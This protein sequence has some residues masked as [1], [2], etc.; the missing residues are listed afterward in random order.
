M[1]Y[2]H[3]IHLMLGASFEEAI[4]KV[5]G[6][7]QSYE[8]KDLADFFTGMSGTVDEEGNMVFRTTQ[9]FAVDNG[10][11]LQ[12]NS[13]PDNPFDVRLNQED[14]VVISK[15]NRQ[16]Y[17]RNFFSRLFDKRVT[18]NRRNKDNTLNICIYLPM[19]DSQYW[20]MARECVEAISS[21]TRNIKVDLFMFAP[22]LAYLLTPE[23]E[24]E[25]LPKHM[26]ELT[27]NGQLILKEAV[28]FK[29]ESPLARSL[30]HIIVMQNCN[31][32]GVALDLDWESFVRIV[33]EFVIATMNSYNSLFHPNAE[34]DDRPIHTFGLCV[35]DL[36]KYYYVKYLLSRAYVTI[37]EREGIDQT[38]VDVNIPAQIVQQAF[39]ADDNCYRFYDKFY[40]RRVRGYLTGGRKVE[41]VNAEALKD[42]DSD[43]S[44]FIVHMT[45]FM[46]DPT[47][48]LPQKR[49]ALAQLLG[50]D[51]EYMSGDVFSQNQLIFRDTYADCV[52]MFVAANNALLNKAPQDV[53]V[54]IPEAETA[55]EE[56]SDYPEMLKYYAVLGEEY[57]D[58]KELQKQLK[59]AELRIRRQTEYIRALE[60]EVEDCDVQVKQSEHKDKILT[61]D[62]FVFGNTVYKT[63]P[64]VSIPLEKTYEPSHR[65]LPKSMDLRKSFSPVRDQGTLGSCTSFAL[66]G[67]Y[68]YILN[69][70]QAKEAEDLS[71]RF[72][73][74]NARLAKLRR[75][76]VL[77]EG[78]PDPELQDTGVSFYDAVT[79]LQSDGICLERLCAY[80]ADNQA[81]VKPES[82]AYEDAKARLVTEA[83][84]VNLS[85]EDIKS[86]L[87]DGY[88]VAI[89]LKIYSSF[90]TPS[91]GFVSLPDP[92]EVKQAEEEGLNPNH[93]MIICGYSDEDKV[94]IIRNSWSA[95]YGD[96][97]YCYVPYSYVT[98]PQLSV[99]ACVITG[100]SVL[101]AEQV[102]GKTTTREV[103]SFD[104][105]NPEINAAI[106]RNLL[107]EAK[108]E[109]GAL[110]AVRTKAYT[111]YTL[112]EK[113]LVSSE[114]R[115]ELT[116]GT[117]A[118]L[119]WEIAYIEQQ[120][121]K[122]FRA[123]DKRLEALSKENKVVN[124]SCAVSVLILIINA[125]ILNWTPVARFL[126]AN[127]PLAKIFFWVLLA[128]AAALGVW[129][130]KYFKARKEVLAEHAA[131]N[132]VL[133][134][135]KGKRV[136][137][138]GDNAGNLGLYTEALEIRMFMP[139]LVM[140]KLSEKNRALEQQ[141]Q[142][143]ISFT[144]NL[145]E[146]YK[147]EKEKTRTM[148]PN[149]RVPFISLLSN[150]T[151]DKFY[152]K[153]A[154][155]ITS[156]LSLSSMFQQGFALDDESIVKFQNQLKNNII[157]TLE[158]SLKEFSVYKYI[159][160][161]TS[162]EFANER[163]FE[164]GNML[165]ELEEKS[166]VFVR[167]G[168]SPVTSAALNST[169]VSLMS[170]DILD[171]EYTWDREFAKHFTTKVSHI[172][173]AS[174]FK[175]AFVKVR[176]FSVQECLDLYNESV[177]T[178]SETVAR[179]QEPKPVE[180]VMEEDVA[181]DV[182]LYVE[183]VEESPLETNPL[184][185]AISA[186]E[187]VEEMEQP[188]ESGE[189]LDEEESVS[190]ESVEAE[191]ETDEVGEPEAIEDVV[192]EVKAETETEAEVEAEDE[193]EVE[194][195]AEEQ[196]EETEEK[197]KEEKL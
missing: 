66:A 13:E 151:L 70:S 88:P 32:D 154:D 15:E 122:N 138:A 181:E 194:T 55:E 168:I 127:I 25:E 102:K 182:D 60:K 184:D 162:F 134:Q 121:A 105:M 18:I 186:D 99:Q 57:I 92:A 36:D 157:A 1:I 4:C 62:G 23:E 175:M 185:E 150:A 2:R 56:S 59:D 11:S 16:D 103:V 100:V 90:A 180:P 94:F 58:F 112:I 64:V 191:L 51:D 35:L 53:S 163:D 189:L 91:C 96:K 9:R 33:G 81:N 133:E 196:K 54:Y 41:D 38:L 24:Q 69:N 174:S 76:G 22:D 119:D 117:K 190:V 125:I 146:W 188:T 101:S 74:Y 118:R 71:E 12:F 115:A 155:S 89:M 79:S 87:N 63:M 148:D 193:T 161:Q 49:V 40:E 131:I 137:G 98:D 135:K 30:G 80:T 84:N 128:C 44:R 65:T 145:R 120:Q 173:V 179:P 129:W 123:Q 45:S 37:M 187:V 143:M 113:K 110:L 141:Y 10:K 86:A 97:G 95:S 46:N 104:K 108:H 42:I 147:I 39:V 21:Q 152:D 197:D 130:Y 132:A 171:D 139:W 158:D 172:R 178:S 114:A 136:H 83:K 82:A 3:M 17:L 116:A 140:R 28:D 7:V 52:G 109:M 19:Y 77:A 159:T 142:T 85:E 75:E 170:S 31:S 6:Y 34:L 50:M 177:W 48:S 144:S 5:M 153:Y 176:S 192:S 78:Q 14:K 73:Y 26:V 8:D 61:Q 156:G 164:V 29:K 183:P 195:E 20:E 43:I 107:G 165:Q 47:L 27:R 167:L 169:T 67:I 111:T 124:I 68:E 93:S 149:C 126:T 160:G 166:Y 106:I 72:L